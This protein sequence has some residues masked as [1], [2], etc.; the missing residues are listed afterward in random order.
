VYHIRTAEDSVLF[1]KSVRVDGEAWD[2]HD[3]PVEGIKEITLAVDA[4]A[5]VQVGWGELVAYGSAGDSGGAPVETAKSYL[6]M[7]DIRSRPQLISGWYSIEDGGWRWMAKQAKAVLRV[8]AKAPSMFAMQLFFPPDYQKRAGGP[9][10]VSVLIDGKPFAVETYSQPGGYRLE[11]PV[12]GGVLSA[13]ASKV[14]I[15]LSRSIPATDADRRELGAVVQEF[16][17]VEQR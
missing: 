13:P 3:I 10:T 8:P 5:N 7:G 16:G 17:F 9:V 1:D 15:N 14:E 2:T 11:R 12:P 4:P 6:K